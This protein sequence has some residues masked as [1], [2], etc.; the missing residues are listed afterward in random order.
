MGGALWANSIVTA[1]F[2]IVTSPPVLNGHI[3]FHIES[4]ENEV[5]EVLR[6]PL[7]RLLVLL[8]TVTI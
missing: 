6:V 5:G 3:L 8:M 1:H 4:V 2:L 7:S